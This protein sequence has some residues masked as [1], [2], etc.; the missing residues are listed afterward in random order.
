M[1]PLVVCLQITGCVTAC[2]QSV[3]TANPDILSLINMVIFR[4]L[5][6]ML[7]AASVYASQPMALHFV[8]WNVW[9]DAD[10][11]LQRFPSLLE[12]VGGWDPDV[13][14]LQEATPSF[15]QAFDQWSKNSPFTLQGSEA[16]RSTYGVAFLS[17]RP[18]RR[19]KE[20]PL[21]SRFHREVL[22]AYLPISETRGVILINTHLE[23][24]KENASVR[25]QQ[26]RKIVEEWLPLY[27]DTLFLY[28]SNPHIVAEVWGGD[29]NF[30]R[31]IDSDTV[32]G[33]IDAAS[34]EQQVL[35][36]YDADTNPLA[37]ESSGW[38][39]EVERL[40]RLYL[41]TGARHSTVWQD[42]EVRN[43]S[44]TRLLSDHYPIFATLKETED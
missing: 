16:S 39:P 30:Y 35:P 33:W 5:T 11:A 38:F 27:R 34:P 31:D 36:T 17:E 23:S 10:S 15:Y 20:H 7:L 2:K 19:V 18:L 42:Y 29:F 41:N 40:D 25:A 1:F 3:P 43:S 8:S 28:E 24:G 6:L 32:P 37:K 22:F 14:F 13:V 12:Y 4:Y 21:P 9:F 26:I 44:R